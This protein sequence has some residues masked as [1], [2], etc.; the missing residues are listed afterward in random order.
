M[1]QC[2]YI[3]A[4]CHKELLDYKLAKEDYKYFRFLI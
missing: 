2:Y 4:L 1:I 3:R